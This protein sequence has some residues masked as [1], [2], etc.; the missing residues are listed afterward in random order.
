MRDEDWLRRSFMVTN[1]RYDNVDMAR[2]ELTDAKYKFTDTTLGATSPLTPHPNS[3]GLLIYR[4]PVVTRV[5]GVR[6]VTTAR[7]SMTVVSM[8]TC[9]LVSLNSTV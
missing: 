3:H 8:S 6:A 5:H 7:H 9:V 4:Y 2:R 1:V